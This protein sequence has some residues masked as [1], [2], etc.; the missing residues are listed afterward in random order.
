MIN[1]IMSM[2]L[3]TH[4]EIKRRL[5]YDEITGLF[6]WRSNGAIAGSRNLVKR[7]IIVG[8]NYRY[9]SAGRLAW[10][11]VYGEWPK[12]LVRHRNGDRFDCRWENLTVDTDRRLIQHLRGGRKNKS[13]AYRGVTLNKGCWTAQISLGRKNRYIGTYPTQEEAARAYDAKARELFGEHAFQNFP[14]VR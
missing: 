13:S 2:D 8:I 4:E 1:I 12:G 7:T 6:K 10:F 9:I 14:E 3:P 11:Y 5:S